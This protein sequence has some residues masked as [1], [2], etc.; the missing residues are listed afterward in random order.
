MS[1]PRAYDSVDAI[2]SYIP[3]FPLTAA[4]LLPRGQMPLNIFEPR[5]LA[6]VDAALSGDRVIGM[7]QPAAALAS[8]R[9]AES[10]QNAVDLCPTGC[11]GKVTGFQETDDGRYLITLSGVIRFKIEE[12]LTVM[13]PYR[14]C[15]ISADGFGDDLTEGL[16]EDEVDRD[17]LLSTFKNYLEANN[18]DADWESVSRAGNESLVNALSMMSPFGAREKQALLE[19]ESIKA[20]ADMLVAMTELMLHKTDVESSGQLQ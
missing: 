7:V 4:L 11:L 20:R 18:M 17:A 15:R 13:T 14:Q 10:P 3:I 1:R 19:A 2:P 9:I 8:P 5:Y 16:N 6:M 12:E